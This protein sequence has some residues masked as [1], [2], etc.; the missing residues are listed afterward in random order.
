M[1]KG[2]KYQHLTKEREA[3]MKKGIFIYILGALML[4][5]LGGVPSVEGASSKGMRIDRV[6]I[7]EKLD[8]NGNL[9]VTKEYQVHFSTPHHGIYK[10]IPFGFTDPI[11]KKDRKIEIKNIK[12]YN[13]SPQGGTYH[14]KVRTYSK[15][16]LVKIGDPHRT[17]TG[18][19]CYGISYQVVG[20]I[21]RPSKNTQAIFWNLVGTGWDL[22]LNNVHAELTLPS[23]VR[24]IRTKC[25]QG[26]YR[27]TNSCTSLSVNGNKIIIDEPLL[28]AH[29]ALSIRAEWT[30][31]LVKEKIIYD[32]AKEKKRRAF[33]LLSI[34]WLITIISVL[35]L[36]YKGSSLSIRKPKMVLYH[37]PEE[38]S[39]LEAGVII[40]NS[41]DGRDI[42]AA[43]ISLAQ[44]GYIRIEKIKDK[45]SLF[46][47]E[48]YQLTLIRDPDINLSPYEAIIISKVFRREIGDHVEKQINEIS[49]H[50]VKGALLSIIQSLGLAKEEE[51]R[52]SVTI[53]EMQRERLGR[54][55]YSEL[56]KVIY[57][58]LQEKGYFARTF[59]LVRGVAILLSIILF[60][61][62]NL[63]ILVTSE[64]V[65][66]PNLPIANIPTNLV[67]FISNGAIGMLLF[68]LSR[69]IGAKTRKGQ[70]IS[71]KL[72]GLKEFI[73]TVETDRLKRMYKDEE[74]PEVFERFLPYAVIFGEEKRWGRAFDPIFL[75]SGYSPGWYHGTDSFKASDFS[76][77]ISSSMASATSGG[78]SGAG[79]G[80]GGGGGGGW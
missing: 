47:S 23:E 20:S 61:P 6:R 77:S 50:R 27:S 1:I 70:E 38:I 44:K 5:F 35:Y 54:E 76:Q 71:W 13:C 14:Y 79:G 53:K 78:G 60:V 63:A 55:L 74:L 10:Y 62:L 58:D 17:I 21:V 48:D 68:N 73:S 30:P 18:N 19:R 40:D 72:E 12:V 33:Y 80:G 75:S 16:L 65:L 3:I 36:W 24:L 7:N 31:P 59:K 32:L 28:L 39:V 51:P 46:S 11:T 49:H 67:L 9:W 42:T 22:P 8:L 69:R 15:D 37:P 34:A 56:S 2:T 66:P 26:S 43:L 29:E 52:T 57:R 4:S 25:Y 64:A 45:N 41:L